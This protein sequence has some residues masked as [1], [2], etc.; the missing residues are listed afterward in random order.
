MGTDRGDFQS[1]HDAGA[2]AASKETPEGLAN[3]I[4]SD[5]LQ[6]TEI[7]GKFGP[8]LRLWRRLAWLPVPLLAGT[9]V[10]LWAADLR[11]SYESPHL[12]IWLHFVFSVLVSV[13][14]INL[15]GRSFLA[16]GAPGLLMLGCG[17]IF[18][19]VSGFVGATAGHLSNS[20]NDFAN[21]TMTI[22]STGVLLSAACH[23][24]GVVLSL[25][26]RQSARPAGLWLATTYAAALIVVGWITISTIA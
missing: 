24:T 9:M 21:I 12:L 1:D 17:V 14:I 6:L 11:T 2:Y 8:T 16:T 3:R 15:I 19:G 10:V 20:G 7:S 26:H 23:L 22:Y 4:S 5:G 13:F 25:R 18:W